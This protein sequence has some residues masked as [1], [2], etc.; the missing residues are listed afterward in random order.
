MALQ[1]LVRQKERSAERLVE[2]ERLGNRLVRHGGS[3][4]RSGIPSSCLG[5]DRPD[6]GMSVHSRTS[7]RQDSDLQIGRHGFE[8]PSAEELVLLAVVPRSVGRPHYNLAA[9][10]LFFRQKLIRRQ[11]HV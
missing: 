10:D 4:S 2:R 7:L 5:H 11:I 9:D 1:L 3:L 8:H 6:G